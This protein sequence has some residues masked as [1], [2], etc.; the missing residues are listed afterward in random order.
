L[1]GFFLRAKKQKRCKTTKSKFMAF[2]LERTQADFF[3][4]RLSG[5]RFIHAIARDLDASD[6]H[7]KESKKKYL[8]ESYIVYLV[9]R[10]QVF[11]E[12]LAEEAFT[13]LAA[14]EPSP[15]LRVI[16]LNNFNQ[17]LKRFNTPKAKNIDELIEAATGLTKISDNWHWDGV[18][19]NTAKSKLGDIL[20]IRHEIAHTGSTQKK[21]TL[22]KN[23]NYVEFLVKLAHILNE[24]IDTHIETELRSRS[25]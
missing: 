8:C 22:A 6:V 2:K 21:L 5:I 11:L 1:S 3:S 9:A 20:E 17:T 23:L 18:S 12:S 15:R 16:R 7:R 25:S 19:I 10:W 24:V 13:R 4:K 14:L